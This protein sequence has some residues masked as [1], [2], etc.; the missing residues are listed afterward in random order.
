MT[1]K[2]ITL[3]DLPSASQ[4]MFKA[5]PLKDFSGDSQ[6]LSNRATS[7]LGIRITGR[8]IT[9]TRTAVD[10]Q[11]HDPEALPLKKSYTLISVERGTALEA[12][13]Y[14]LML[15]LMDETFDRGEELCS[16]SYSGADREISPMA[17]PDFDKLL[18]EVYSGKI[19][20]RSLANGE[21]GVFYGDDLMPMTYVNDHWSADLEAAPQST[22]DLAKQTFLSTL[23]ALDMT[24]PAVDRWAEMHKTGLVFAWE[25]DDGSQTKG[26]LTTGGWSFRFVSTE[27]PQVQ[28]VLCGKTIINTPNL[29]ESAMDLLVL[30][31]VLAKI[32]KYLGVEIDA[33]ALVSDPP[34]ILTPEEQRLEEARELAT[35]YIQGWAKI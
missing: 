7:Y 27:E 13:P 23:G 19:H 17:L 6:A 14:L 28:Y 21:E 34:K 1:T 16:L 22:I 9:L 8:G 18:D 4:K 25:S 31:A 32:A 12:V 3:L 15:K 26:G 5:F 29:E 10:Y 20:I 24:I 30:P 33:Q 11:D 2:A 35:A